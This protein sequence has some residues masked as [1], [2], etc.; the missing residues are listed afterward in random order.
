METK[1]SEIHQKLLS[2]YIDLRDTLLF[3]RLFSY[4]VLLNEYSKISRKSK[5]ENEKSSCEF[6]VLKY[7]SIGETMHSTL[8]ADLLNPEADHGQ[9]AFFL[10]LF[11]EKLGIE[12]PEKGKWFVTPEK[13]R[14]D[15]LIKRNHPHSV[16]VI[17][18]KSENAI[19][20]PNQLYRYWYYQI[21][22]PTKSLGT[23]YSLGKKDK[24][25]IVYLPS[26]S[27][28]KPTPNTLSKPESL[29]AE[30]DLPESLGYTGQTDH[31]KPEQIDQ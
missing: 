10:N 21:Y 15:I 11:L 8:L 22:T 25:R 26:E 12:S 30:T 9:G 29:K 24:Y 14:I 23:K 17:E 27:F 16:I 18:N 4:S 20:Q 7:F 13:E 6:N 2:N 3:R 19:D 31:L 28:K 5:E 1:N